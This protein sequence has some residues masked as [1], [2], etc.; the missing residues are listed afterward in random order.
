[1]CADADQGIGTQYAAGF[2]DRQLVLAHVNAVGVGQTGEIA[3]SFRMNST[4]AFGVHCGPRGPVQGVRVWQI[5]FTHCHDVHAAGCG[6]GDGSP[7]E[8]SQSAPVT[9]K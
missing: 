6:L 4:L 7:I 3:R 2:L 9:S 8:A 5:L 1:V